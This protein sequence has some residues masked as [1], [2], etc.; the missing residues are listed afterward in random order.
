MSTHVLLKALLVL[1]CNCC[2]PHYET[3]GH[4]ATAFLLILKKKK[5]ILIQRQEITLSKSVYYF[6]NN[7]KSAVLNTALCT[8][9]LR[10]PSSFSL[11]EST[12]KTPLCTTLRP[13]SIPTSPTVPRPQ[14]WLAPRKA[15]CLDQHMTSL[16][17]CTIHN[18]IFLFRQWW[19][20]CCNSF[21][22]SVLIIFYP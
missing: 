16:N 14:L 15:E 4:I 21:S 19:S 3:H 13:C 18:L 17:R 9:S 22:H 2:T 10:L 8:F 1:L 6:P 20:W 7:R 11:P 5:N 12:L